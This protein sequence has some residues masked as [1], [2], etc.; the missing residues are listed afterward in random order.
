MGRK[1]RTW[2]VGDIRYWSHPPFWKWVQLV[3]PRIIHAHLHLM[4]SRK[5]LL[6]WLTT[7]YGNHFYRLCT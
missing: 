6:R 1:T 7:P 2:I 3:T 5:H 4:F